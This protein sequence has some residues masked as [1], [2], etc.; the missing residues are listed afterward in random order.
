LALP[1]LAVTST[2]PALVAAGEIALHEVL[3][4]QLTDAAA[5][6]PNLKLVPAPVA[7]P[8]PVT[9]TVVPPALGPESGLTPVTVG[10]ANLKWSAEEIALVPLGVVTL[11][12]TVPLVAG[13][14]TAVIELAELTVKPAAALAPNDTAV[15]SVKLV[16][17]IVTLVAPLAGPDLGAR[18]LTVGVGGAPT[19]TVL[20]VPMLVPS[21][22]NTVSATR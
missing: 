5:R 11:T 19:T 13:G 7:N 20:A 1:T 10:A 6:V 12:S 9:V 18:L 22:A 4:A 3:E 8:L 17:A 21:L 16:P 15:A 2:F 14:E